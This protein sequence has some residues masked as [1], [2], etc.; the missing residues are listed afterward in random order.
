MLVGLL[1]GRVYVQILDATHYLS[2]HE[3]DYA[4]RVVTFVAE[5]L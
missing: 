3:Y 5:D 1:G 4:L 2:D